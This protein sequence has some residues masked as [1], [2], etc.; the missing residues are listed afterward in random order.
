M[1]VCMYVRMYNMY[2][3]MYVCTYIAMCYIVCE[4]KTVLA[5]NSLYDKGP[6]YHASISLIMLY[7][8]IL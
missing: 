8:I 7:K 1:Y 2:V 3:C 4:R 5:I 6:G